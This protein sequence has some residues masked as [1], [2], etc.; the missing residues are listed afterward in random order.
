MPGSQTVD[1]ARIQRSSLP[2]VSGKAGYAS[3]RLLIRY[4]AP[5]F[6][7]YLGEVSRLGYERAQAQRGGGQ[8]AHG[9]LMQQSG[10]GRPGQDGEPGGQ[11]VGRRP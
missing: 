1:H 8:V 10:V 3:I 5:V 9:G 11:T 6:A 7:P 4:P 2:D